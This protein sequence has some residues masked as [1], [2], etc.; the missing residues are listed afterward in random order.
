MVNIALE[1]LWLDPHLKSDSWEAGCSAQHSNKFMKV[2]DDVTFAHFSC[3][4]CLFRLD[5]SFKFTSED[6]DQVE[7]ETNWSVFDESF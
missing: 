3:H 4:P 6:R 7:P 5:F 1:V 2:A